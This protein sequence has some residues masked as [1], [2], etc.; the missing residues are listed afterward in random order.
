MIQIG[1]NIS[2]KGAGVSGPPPAPVNTVLPVISGTTTL[3]SVLTT[4][5]GTWINS[6]SSFTYQWK[7]NATNIGTNAN[8]YTLV[9]ADSGADITC[10]VTAINGGG[11]TSATSNIITAQTY[12]APAIVS[13]PVISGTTTLGSVLTTT[14]GVWTGNPTPT[15]TY[16]WKRG[17]T[18][19]GTNSSTYTLVLADSN[20]AI[21]CVV[22]AT[23]VLGSNNSTSNIIT[24]DNYAPVNTVAP[25]LS[26][27][28]RVEGQLVTTDNGTWDNSPTSF[29]YQ[30]YRDATPI[31]GETL[32]EYALDAAD[33]DTYVSCQV[34][35][36][37]AG[38]SSTPEPSDA[39]YI[40]DYEYSQVY[41][42]Y[43]DTAAAESILQNQFMLAI[44]AAGVWAKLDVLCVFRGSGDNQALIDWKRLTEVI[45]IDCTFESAKGFIG[46][47][48]IP[49]YIDTGFV[50]AGGTNY[51]QNNASRYFFPFDF[52]G[53][54]PMDG[55]I[56][57][58]G[59]SRNKMLLNNSTDHK[60]NQ[61]GAVP[62]SSAFQY[63]TTVEPKSIH[64]TSAT[65]VT[66]FNGTTS[67]S[68]TAL[69]T[70]LLGGV[71]L[72]ILRDTNDYADHTVAAYATGASMVAENT[73]FIAAWNTYI[74]AL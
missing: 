23:N 22:T 31:S 6:P 33:A 19:I 62:L 63:T 72:F 1:I 34:T 15:F 38:G 71:N 47:A 12:S 59:G 50:A 32:N 16:Q 28:N 8:T 37:N 11:S 3:G 30:W 41:Y 51:T 53:N 73:A 58:G 44:K 5:N 17:A 9:L 61:N 67:A 74:T 10:V 39:I 7:R 4:T 65:D 52:I 57:G 64:R 18:N 25:A 70:A 48:S 66:L 56:Q 54:G 36:I 35:A 26:Y 20:S 69:S 49:A 13:A 55:T 14:D 45:N 21:T 24:A 68:R 29:T 2:V 27:G 43:E 46:K 60:I 42:Y 40:F